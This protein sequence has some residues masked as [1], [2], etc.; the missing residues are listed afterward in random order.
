MSDEVLTRPTEDRSMVSFAVY[1]PAGKIIQ[2]GMCPRWQIDLQA[3]ARGAGAVAIEVAT[4][5]DPS[6]WY[7]LDGSVTQRPEMEIVADKETIVGDGV[8]EAMFSG[9]PNPCDVTVVVAGLVIGNE[10]SED[11]S[12]AL[13]AE[14]PGAYSVTLS[15]WPYLDKTMTV[16]AE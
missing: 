6:S 1:D 4:I 16:T 12:F 5:P 8:D 11:G 9:L 10:T 7:V 2:T 15:A 3:Q 13:S 14:S